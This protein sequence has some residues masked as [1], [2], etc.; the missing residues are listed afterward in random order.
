MAEYVTREGTV[1]GADT[2][3]GLTTLGSEAT[4][5]AI[6]V[7]TGTSKIAQIIAAAAGDGTGV[8][9]ATWI[10]RIG[11]NGVMNGE[12][13]LTLGALGGTLNTSDIQ[14]TG[15]I[16]I[17]VDIPVKAGKQVSLSA[18]MCGTDIGSSEVSVTI[19]FT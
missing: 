17:P 16:I 7:P 15:A 6:T 4:P 18:E 8:G 13:T 10:L 1:A 11:G 3:T 2:K 14:T 5:G 12:Q 9:A 19:A